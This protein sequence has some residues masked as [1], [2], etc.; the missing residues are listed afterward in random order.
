MLRKL[1][2]EHSVKTPFYSQDVDSQDMIN[3]HQQLLILFHQQKSTHFI[4]VLL[5]H[6]FCFWTFS[7]MQILW[8][9]WIKSQIFLKYHV[10]HQLSQCLIKSTINMIKQP[11]IIHYN[12]MWFLIAFDHISPNPYAWINSIQEYDLY[13]TIFHHIDVVT[14]QTSIWTCFWTIKPLTTYLLNFVT[15]IQYSTK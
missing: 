7:F 10:L 11:I 14:K 3:G 9:S 5:Y 1:C 6:E 8:W 13:F 2:M 15:L 12:S 4:S